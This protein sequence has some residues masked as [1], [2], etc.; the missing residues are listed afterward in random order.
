MVCFGVVGIVIV[1]RESRC[2][3]RFER[4][5]L[6]WQE[7]ISDADISIGFVKG[8]GLGAVLLALVIIVYLLSRRPSDKGIAAVLS[9]LAPKAISKRKIVK[10]DTVDA[11]SKDTQQTIEKAK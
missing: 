5:Q 11:I 1:E 6:S 4:R 2:N 7:L 8:T 10:D 3:E 9:S